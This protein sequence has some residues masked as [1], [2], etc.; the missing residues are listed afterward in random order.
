MQ[1]F[2]HLTIVDVHVRA[3]TCEWISKNNAQEKKGSREKNED[4]NGNIVKIV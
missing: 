2:Q 4:R 1:C 3:L